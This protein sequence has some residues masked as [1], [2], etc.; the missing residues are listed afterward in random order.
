MTPKQHAD[1]WARCFKHLV[2]REA[3]INVFID[4]H[5]NHGSETLKELLS[6]LNVRSF[7]DLF[8]LVRD[9][10]AKKASEHEGKTV[11]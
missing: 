9:G 7:R 1:D 8:L 5:D 2:T 10:N 6:I 3:R 11:G 4:A